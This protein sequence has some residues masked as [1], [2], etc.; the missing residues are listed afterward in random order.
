[1]QIISGTMCSDCYAIFGESQ[2]GK[3]RIG[4]R[5]L[6]YVGGMQSFIGFRV[7]AVP[8]PSAGTGVMPHANVVPLGMEAPSTAAGIVEAFPG[9]NFGKVDNKRASFVG[10]TQFGI[11]MEHV[12]ALKALYQS[13]RFASKLMGALTSLIEQV[14]GTLVDEDEV[15]QWINSTYLS[16]FEEN[17]SA[18]QEYKSNNQVQ[19]PESS[20]VVVNLFETNSVEVKE[21]ET[22]SLPHLD[23]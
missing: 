5:P 21:G 15:Y 16:L 20:K 3:Y 10:G 2:N 8:K 23:S 14:S 11:G 17:E 18:Y 1:M 7:R 6:V 12:D 13:T 22:P 4:I 9:V 19:L